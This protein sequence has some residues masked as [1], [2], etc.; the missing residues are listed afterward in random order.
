MSERTRSEELYDVHRDKAWEDIKS[1]N[2]NFDKYM[3]TFSSGALGLSL[4]FIKDVVPAEDCCLDNLPHRL[5][6]C[7]R[8]LHLGYSSVISPQHHGP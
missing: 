8:T 4:A 6:D 7:V 2:E 1:G 5:L 3:L